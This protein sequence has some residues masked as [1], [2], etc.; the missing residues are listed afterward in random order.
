MRPGRRLAKIL[1]WGLVL[2]LLISAG[3]GW[4][5]YALVT[6][7]E[8]AARLIKAQAARFLPRSMV[9]MGRINISIFKG[10]VTVS[11]F[12]VR[13]RIDGQPFLTAR[14]PWLSVR[15][16]AR[17]V[18]HGQFVPREVV[19]SQP[20]LRLCRRSDG[21]WN[22]QGL[23]A[24]PWPGQTI[25]NPPPIVIRNGTI[26]LVGVEDAEAGSAGLPVPASRFARGSER[27]L[28]R[29]AEVVRA[30]DSAARSRGLAA[31]P[32]SPPAVNKGVAPEAA[33]Q[34]TAPKGPAPAGAL[35]DHGVAIL[36]D[37]SLRIEAADGGRLR[38]EGS[39]RGDLFEKLTL[40]GTIDPTTGDT[41]LRGELAGLTLS[42]NLRRRLPPEIRSPF[43]A[44]G[45]NRGEID[46]ELRRLALHP[47]A[48]RD[49]RFD[50]DV[51]A[52]LHGG[53]WE[54]PSLPFPV[55][56]LSAF[57]TISNGLLT[58]KHAEGSN[59][60]TILRA[61]GLLALGQSATGPFDLR[62]DLVQLELDKRLQERTPAQFAELWDV[63]K[64]RGLVDAYIHLARQQ[65]NGPVGVGARV[66]CRDV[67][68]VYRHFSYLVEHMNGSL[69]LEKQR[70]SVDLRGLIGERP[71]L[72]K[73]TIDNPGPDALV[74]LDVLADSVPIDAAFLAALPPDIRKVV[75]QFHPAGSVKAKVHILRKPMFGP[76]AKPEGH[77]VIDADLDLNPRCEI[78][79]AGLPYPIR[80]LTGR[81]ELHPDLWIFKNMR[82]G[83]GQA[84]ITG[85]GRVQKI[86]GPN[87]PNG[88]PPLKIDL[89]IQA[90]NL[91]FN[92][93]LRKALQPAWQKTWAIINPTGASDVEASI[94]IEPGRPDI[95]HISIV[96]RPESSVRLV[97][98]PTPQ[99]GVDPGGTFELRMEN[100]HGRFDFD[101]GKVVMNDVGFLFHGAPVQFTSGTV[102][103]EDS[104]RFALA[105]SE[106]WV[107]EIRFDSSLLTIMPPLMA[108]FALRLDDGR[109]F[110]ARG[111][112]QIG[113]SGVAGEPAW[114]R[115]DNTRVVFIDNTLKAGIPLE[116]IQGQLE[117][118]RGWSNGQ[119]MEI[120][121]IVRLDSVSLMGQQITDVESPFH[122]ERGS[123]RLD[124]LK[125]K[126]L[127][128]NLEGS[129]TISLHDTPKYSASL[130]LAGAQLEEYARTLPGRQSYRGTLGAAIDLSGLGNNVRSIQGK[131]EAH[132]TQGDLGELPVA[133]RFINFLN[134]KLSLLDSP[135]TSGKTAFDSADVE[136]RIDHGTAVLDP[137]KLTGSAF[138]LQG[139]GNRDPLGNLDIQL[140]VL[141]GRD[142]LHLPIVSDL[143]R[144]ASGQF[145]IVHVLG[146]SSNPRFQLETLPQVRK[147]GTRRG[148]RKPE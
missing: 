142:R 66:L 132:I 90:K 31:I 102:T 11:Q 118:V 56:D 68:A 83:N 80:N 17:Q 73:G 34:S 117:E 63:F 74:R 106:L 12:L 8:T 112:L 23:I 40:E 18:L 116:H 72:L 136:F 120:H 59:G 127:K 51:L 113:W 54:C 146:P 71:A 44:L 148:Q 128:G 24:E 25:K 129:G 81:L 37:V 21:T 96:P 110:T 76:R 61:T 49:R 14:V 41:V 147:L 69:T 88:E 144:E 98:H 101:N 135:L 85:D 78:T 111:N 10:E 6:D 115:W 125:G 109:P 64:P 27:A 75:D 108:Q 9:E 52:R 92:D 124:S 60:N 119:T 103:V 16:D 28:D 58:V 2:I 53:V 67:K 141:Y 13:Q 107:K 94:H 86:A 89:Q 45:L 126:L 140:K 30:R 93:D 99:P 134:S 65:E 32:V 46:L 121:G 3:A 122:L 20:T 82:G 7:S 137:I 15:L 79:W 91:P 29:D 38:F 87:L 4:F 104:G 95:N 5:A 123:A 35:P 70:L 55:N 130:R 48:P 26:E 47:G 1:V 62:L 19:V 36:R 43:E 33:R 97:I 143:M 139:S 22:I 84:I 138:S 114:C 50:Y 145:L 100:V 105:V 57:V 77:V 133:L 42:E 39:A 131:G